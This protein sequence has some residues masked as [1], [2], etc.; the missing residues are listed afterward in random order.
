[1]TERSAYF[2]KYDENFTYEKNELISINNV[3]K[4]EQTK[5]FMM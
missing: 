5:N 2:L 3:L 4:Y 1:M